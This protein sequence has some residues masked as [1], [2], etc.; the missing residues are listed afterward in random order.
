M[1]LDF[2]AYLA[3]LTENE[4][5]HALE[6]LWL[7]GSTAAIVGALFIETALWQFVQYASQTR[8]LI[9]YF[10]HAINTVW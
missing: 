3:R 2:D 10:A 8:L 4:R 9:M 6:Q 5:Y 7:W 1:R